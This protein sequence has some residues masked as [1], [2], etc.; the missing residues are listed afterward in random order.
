MCSPVGTERLLGCGGVRHPFDAVVEGAQRGLDPDAVLEL[1]K[2]ARRAAPNEASARQWFGERGSQLARLLRPDIPGKRTRV[3]DGSSEPRGP[4]IPGKRTRV[5][6]GGHEPFGLDDQ[7]VVGLRDLLRLLG[8]E[9]G[10]RGEVIAAADASIANR[11]TLWRDRRGEG[12]GARG[13]A[14]WGAAERHAA[15]LYRRATVGAP[16]LEDPAVAA[17]LERRGAGHALPDHLRSELE[18]ELGVTLGGVCVHTDDLAARAA[19]ALGAEAFTLGEDVFF[20]AGRFAPETATGRA[21]IAHELAHVAQARRAPA[22][23]GALRVSSPSDPHEHEAEGVASR[24]LERDAVLERMGRLFGA[25]FRRVA[26]HTDSPATDGAKAIARG[27]EV[28]VAPGAFRP[29]TLEGDHVIAHEL[30]HVV[31]A[32]APGPAGSRVALEAEA[33]GAADRVARGEPA[34]VQLATA[35]NAAYPYTDDNSNVL[36]DPV[37][38]TW[39]GDAFHLE[40]RRDAAQSSP[41]FMCKL[42]YMGPHPMDGVG[43]HDAAAKATEFGVMVTPSQLHARLRS[44]STNALEIDLLGDGNQIIR[45][46]DVASFDPQRGRVHDT[47][48][49]LNRAPSNSAHFYVHDAKAKAGDIAVPSPEERPGTTPVPMGTLGPNAAWTVR[50][51]ADGDQ[52]AELELQLRNLTTSGPATRVRMTIV[53][54]ATKASVS[55]ELQLPPPD[56]TP[57]YP[58]GVLGALLPVVK[59]INDGGRSTILTLVSTATAASP[60]LVIDPPLRTAQAT[61]YRVTAPGLAEALAFP[62][63]TAHPVFGTGTATVDGNIVNVDLTL[64]AYQDKFRLTIQPRTATTAVLGLAQLFRG[65]LRSA[66][67]AELQIARPVM[68]EQ[69]VVGPTSLELDLDGDHK[70]DLMV[71]DALTTPVVGAAANPENDRDHHIRIVGAAIGGER[72]FEFRI[73]ANSP[74]V[75]GGTSGADHIAGSNATAIDGLQ[76]QKAEGTTLAA[77]LDAYEAAMIAERRKAVPSIIRQATLTAWAA[78]SDSLIKLRGAHADAGLQRQAAAQADAF[79][80]ELATDTASATKYQAARGVTVET[81]EYTHTQRVGGYA[82][83]GSGPQLASDL[84]Q[85]NVQA[86]VVDYQALVG[87][88]DQWIADRTAAKTQGPDADRLQLIVGQRRQLGELDGLGAQRIIAVFQPD[89]K[90]KNEQGYVSQ[91]PLSLYYWKAGSTWH[92][93]NVSNPDHV[94][95]VTA[96]AGQ[97]EAASLRKLLGELDDPDRLPAGLIH[98][99]VPGKTAGEVKTR[100]G[101]TWKKALTYLGLALAAAGFTLATFGTGA[102][103]VV[104]VWVA[105]GAGLASA[106]AAGLDLYDKHV[107][108]DLTTKT[109]LLDLAQIVSGLAG[110]SALASGRITVAAANASAGARWAGDWA[111]IAVLS[112]KLYLPATRAAAAADAISFAVITDDMARDLDKVD[113]DGKLRLLIQWAGMATMTSLSIKNAVP[114]AGKTRTLVLSPGPDG[115]PVATLALNTDSTILDSQISIALDKAKRGAGL[116][117]AQ[118]I[119]Q[120][121]NLSPLEKTLVARAKAMRD[122]R[123]TDRGVVELGSD[124]GNR[125]TPIG[126]ERT[127]KEYQ[128][129]VQA[130]E[131]KPPV[132]RAKG[133]ADRQIVA[134][135]FFAVTEPG[136]KPTLATGDA[137]VYNPLAERAGIKTARLG[138]KTVP[139]KL[140]SPEGC[141]ATRPDG[142]QVNLHGDRFDVTV[143]GRTITVI[144]IK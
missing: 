13:H 1:W 119:E 36:P 138:G 79:L 54:L 131:G 33:N 8:S 21:L 37:D 107:H 144:P 44:Q 38:V 130:L 85:G 96:D 83:T 51:D 11:A 58:A 28:R 75:D 81:N 4:D 76:A 123:V 124:M 77:H 72:T 74:M 78:L 110:A 26:L 132:G 24:I 34:T 136:A 116:T 64:G 73:R 10:L 6:D 141:P 52:F 49:S 70:P 133:V 40:F 2:S 65:A 101:M 135:S 84:R 137:G 53:Q 92:L 113:A 25:D 95:T 35:G 121:V 111:R 66:Q 16:R 43:I 29:G 117:E 39:N 93:R 12:T 20:A 99:E 91:V 30:A 114:G 102:I 17:A 87:G 139:E 31:Q 112:S 63:S 9:H 5:V 89:A 50:L 94:Y 27:T 32:N 127:S 143:N 100:D 140:A 57:G 60:Q 82:S 134:D 115:I 88:L 128:D 80:K 120:R 62:V 3:A 97:D 69:I 59:Q 103:E 47:T 55:R 98:Y 106:G 105:A 23:R 104:G 68:F 71:Y 67:G 22:T 14:L 86:A 15:M 61:T 41:R 18:R 42:T 19:D 90:F 126:V 46:E 118:Q 48:M 142:T 7:R 125:G 56:T 129:M 122:S 108:G 45:I 109:A